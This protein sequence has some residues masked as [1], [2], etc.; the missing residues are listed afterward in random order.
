MNKKYKK[1]D[2]FA[3]DIG[4]SSASAAEAEVKAKLTK[5]IIVEIKKQNLTHQEVAE[6]SGIS[7]TTITGIVS[8]SLQKITVDRLLRVA[9]SVG[10]SVDIK[11]KKSA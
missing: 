7:R 2:Q 11:I 10:L 4:V 1:L 5:A 6:Q 3:E 8:G 9:S